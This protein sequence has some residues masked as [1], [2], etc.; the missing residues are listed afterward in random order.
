[1]SIIYSMW[2]RTCHSI[3][4]IIIAN[5]NNNRLTITTARQIWSKYVVDS[6]FYV[7][8]IGSDDFFRMAPVSE[9]DGSA[10]IHLPLPRHDAWGRSSWRIQNRHC[11]TACRSTDPRLLPRSW[12]NRCVTCVVFEPQAINFEWNAS[13]CVVVMYVLLLF[14]LKCVIMS[15]IRVC[16]LWSEA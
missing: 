10:Q 4:E 15:H 8:V 9:D 1:M 3:V 6:V 13:L 11:K 5:V 14:V 2:Y 12:T 7:D 16:P